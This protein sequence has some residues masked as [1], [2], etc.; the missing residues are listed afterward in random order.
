VAVEFYR[1]GTKIVGKYVSLRKNMYEP[2]LGWYFM[3][4]GHKHEIK[5]RLLSGTA[6]AVRIWGQFVTIPTT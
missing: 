2:D 3:D 6:A 1:D 4:A 5:I